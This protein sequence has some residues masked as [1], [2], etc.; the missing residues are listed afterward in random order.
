[1]SLKDH[2]TTW[3]HRRQHFARF[4][5]MLSLGATDEHCAR[6]TVSGTPDQLFGIRELKHR[7]LSA[8]DGN[9]KSNAF[10]FWRGFAPYHGQEKVLLMTVA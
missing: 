9:R 6:K 5:Q 1:M 7:R 10:L 2:K 4:A 3:E 8:T